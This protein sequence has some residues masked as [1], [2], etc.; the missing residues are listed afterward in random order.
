M[1]T[2]LTYIDKT[3]TMYPSLGNI[4]DRDLL[5]DLGRFN[6]A[7][8]STTYGYV[9]SGEITLPS[10]KVVSQGEYFSFWSRDPAL[11]EYTGKVVTFT[12]IGFKGQ[13]VIGTLEDKG[14]LVYIDGCTDTLLVYPPRSG[15]PSM[16]AL[17]FPPNTDQTMHIHPSIRMGTVVRGNGSA[18]IVDKDNEE[19]GITLEEGMLF[20]LEE[21]EKHKFRTSSKPLVIIAFHPDGDWGPTDENHTMINRTYVR[22]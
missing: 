9:F 20:C 11:F 22:K 14:R 1:I 6:S 12:R 21:N 15:D 5:G 17:Y 8:F 18:I 10:E 2:E 19:V 13:N 16:S 3:E 4:F 7:P